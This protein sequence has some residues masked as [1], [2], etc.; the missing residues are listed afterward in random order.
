MRFIPEMHL[1]LPPSLLACWCEEMAG[2]EGTRVAVCPRETEAMR[3]ARTAPQKTLVGALLS[4]RGTRKTPL[5]GSAPAVG[6]KV[7]NLALGF[8]MPPGWGPR[9]PTRGKQNIWQRHSP[10]T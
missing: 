10:Y 6:S 3:G 1:P 8:P 4:R 7:A 9:R 2:R 5:A